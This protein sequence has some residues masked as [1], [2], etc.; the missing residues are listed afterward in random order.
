MFNVD[1]AIKFGSNEIIIYQKGVG[2][3][4]KEPAF[5]AVEEDG[6]RLKVKATG[7]RAEKM[8]LS[9]S[10]NLS[11]YQPIENSEIVNKKLAIIL[12]KQVLDQAVVHDL[13]FAKLNALVAVPCALNK[14]Q[15]NE[16][17]D[18][19]QSSGV[20]SVTFVQNSVCVREMLEIEENE[21][22]AV[23]DIGKYITDISVLNQYDF[24]MGRMYLLGGADM[25]K[26]I[27][28]FIEDNHDLLVSDLTSQEVKNEIASLYDRDLYKTEYIG[29]DADNKYEKHEISASEVKVAISNVYDAIF[30]F[31]K[32]MV[33]KLPKEIAANVHKNGVVLVGGASVISGLYE[34][35]KKR[36]EM[37]VMI[38]EEPADSVIIGAGKLLSCEHEF[39]TIKC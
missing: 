10:G 25:D 28:T 4:A 20:S 31:V 35:A 39:I 16:V 6:K 17:K 21:Y 36:L 24:N 9:G 22:V 34:Y 19:L 12:M 2:I 14:S 1:I 37:P 11:V 26:S 13:K 33:E 32:E 7:R 38:P 3:I 29:I 5:L 15:L 30:E 23:V 8:F 18:V 27:T